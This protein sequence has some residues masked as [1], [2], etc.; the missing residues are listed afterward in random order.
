VEDLAGH[1]EVFTIFL[2]GTFLVVGFHFL[3]GYDM[4]VEGLK[5]AGICGEDEE[6][7][8]D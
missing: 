5:A 4:V 7:D 3:G 6:E 1:V 2:E 8:E